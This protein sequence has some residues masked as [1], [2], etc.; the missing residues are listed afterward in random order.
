MC[1]LLLALPLA[2]APVSS[3]MLMLLLVLVLA[4]VPRSYNA[5]ACPLQRTELQFFHTDRGARLKLL[6]SYQM[7]LQFF[8]LQLSEPE[9][10]T[11]QRLPDVRPARALVR[12][13]DTAAG[14]QRTQP[15]GNARAPR[16]RPRWRTSAS[17]S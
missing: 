13:R 5:E 16:G 7:L 15:N 11:V 8:G 3:L 2:P 17:S 6:R 1:A 9:W 12:P 4:L 14:W 10:G